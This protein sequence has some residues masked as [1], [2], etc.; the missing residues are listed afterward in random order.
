MHP[1]LPS[2]SS[3]P[4]LLLLITILLLSVILERANGS[5]VKMIARKFPLYFLWQVSMLESY[6]PGESVKMCALRQDEII[7]IF[8][9]FIFIVNTVTNIPDLLP[10]C[11]PLPSSRSPS[12]WPSTYCCLCLHRHWLIPSPSFI[13]FPPLLSPLTAVSLFHVWMPL[14]LFCSSVYFVC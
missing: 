4:F 8:S 3:C 11:L 7:I 10:S 6:F 13:H 9:P 12:C 14:F 5:K 2:A 1:F